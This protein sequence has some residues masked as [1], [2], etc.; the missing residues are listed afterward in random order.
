MQAFNSIPFSKNTLYKSQGVID[1]KEGGYRLEEIVW[2]QHR[3][4]WKRV[5]QVARKKSFSQFR[6]MN[7]VQIEDIVH[8]RLLYDRLPI[9]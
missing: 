2:L 9:C 4:K 1:L 6:S 3:L 8:S 7:E 5:G